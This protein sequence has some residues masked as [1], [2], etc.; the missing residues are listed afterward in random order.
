MI[1]N[2]RISLKPYVISGNVDGLISQLDVSSGG[3][4]LGFW[5]GN[6]PAAMNESN[7]AGTALLETTLGGATV[8][9]WQFLSDRLPWNSGGQQ[10]WGGLSEKYAMGARGNISVFQTPERAFDAKG[11]LTW[12]GGPTWQNRELPVVQAL[13]NQGIVNNINYNLVRNPSGYVPGL[14]RWH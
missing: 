12:Q 4:P 8:N 1:F 3:K 9:N 14:T 13:Q 10:F 5:S 7:I 6:L 2:S 11:N